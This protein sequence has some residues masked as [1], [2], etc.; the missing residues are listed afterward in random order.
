[1]GWGKY[2]TVAL[3][4]AVI[5]HVVCIYAAP[6]VMMNVAIDRIGAGGSNVWRLAERVTPAS[7]QIVRPSPDFAYSACVFD[8]SEGPLTIS[9]APWSQYW[10][11]SLYA[12]NSDNFYVIDDREAH[13][14]AGITLIRRGKARP[15]GAA[16]VVESPSERGI[17]LIRRLAPSPGTYSA[18]AEASRRDVCAS[19]ARLAG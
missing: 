2:A 5:V 3:L 6:R 9:A 11:L 15:D 8:L 12:A 19:L 10:S 14:G 16:T 1:M 18:A 17:A 13:Y 4:I 7:R